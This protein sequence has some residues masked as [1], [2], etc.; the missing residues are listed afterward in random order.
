[1]Q[2]GPIRHRWVILLAAIAV[3]LWTTT[4]WSQ[5]TLTPA[6]RAAESGDKELEPASPKPAR[7][8]LMRLSA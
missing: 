2:F 8:G 1:M 3:Y 7:D 4:T 5:A 6:G